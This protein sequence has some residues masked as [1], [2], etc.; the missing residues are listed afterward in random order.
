[1]L[2]ASASTGVESMLSRSV[3]TTTSPLRRNGSPLEV[4]DPQDQALAMIEEQEVGIT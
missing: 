3:D 1:M 2:R 4:D